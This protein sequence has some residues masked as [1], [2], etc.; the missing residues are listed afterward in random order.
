MVSPNFRQGQK[1]VHR[2]PR[3]GQQSLKMPI[4]IWKEKINIQ[5][6]QCTIVYA[7]F[8]NYKSNAR[9]WGGDIILGET[10]SKKKD[11]QREKGDIFENA[12]H[13]NYG[14]KKTTKTGKEIK[15]AGNLSRLRKL[16][17]RRKKGGKRSILN[18]MAKYE[19]KPKETFP[20]LF[21]KG[22]NKRGR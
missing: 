11:Q 12:Y 15:T 2:A 8:K 5:G 18:L 22:S 10:K 3:A 4:S 7:T 13:L 17:T 20:L 6:R 9:T 14:E 16:V 19:A 21:Q 1:S